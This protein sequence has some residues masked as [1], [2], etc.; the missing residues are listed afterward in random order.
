MNSNFKFC[1]IIWLSLDL[2]NIEL[3]IYCKEIHSKSKAC[4]THEWRIILL[5]RRNKLHINTLKHH[6]SFAKFS[7]FAATWW[8]MTCVICHYAPTVSSLACKVGPVINVM[9]MSLQSF[10]ILS[11][12]ISAVKTCSLI[13]VSFCS[14]PSVLADNAYLRSV[15]S[16]IFVHYTTF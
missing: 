3:S 15:I 8:S 12:Y 4:N 16:N 9:V 14:Y 10:D 2:D 6:Y 5:G 11:W 1:T 7:V 13:V